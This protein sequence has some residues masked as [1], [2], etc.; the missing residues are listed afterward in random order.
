M[1]SHRNHGAGKCRVMCEQFEYYKRKDFLKNV[2]ELT[3][4]RVDL[5]YILLA[6][7]SCRYRFIFLV[8]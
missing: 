5:L 3:G 1:Q 7:H 6:F 2:K 4:F 8:M